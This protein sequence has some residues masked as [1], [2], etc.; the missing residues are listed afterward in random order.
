[1][2]LLEAIGGGAGVRTRPQIFGN[3]PVA[4]ADLGCHIGGPNNYF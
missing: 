4:H 1:M 2:G 3:Y